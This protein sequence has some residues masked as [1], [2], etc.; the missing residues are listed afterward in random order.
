[1]LEDITNKYGIKI[2]NSDGSLRNVVDVL[3]DMYIRLGR[4]EMIYMFF[5]MSEEETHADIFDNARGRKY[6]GVK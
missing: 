4:S 2:K 3:E 1:M 5:E 6:Q